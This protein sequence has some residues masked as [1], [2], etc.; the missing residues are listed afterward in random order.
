MFVVK[1]C[2]V[3]AGAR[4][5]GQEYRHRAELPPSPIPLLLVRPRAPPGWS[6]LPGHHSAPP[7]NTVRAC[8]KDPNPSQR[9]QRPI[10][11]S[12]EARGSRTAGLDRD[13]RSNLHARRWREG[14]SNPYRP[15]AGTTSRAGMRANSFIV[16]ILAACL[17]GMA[18]A[19]IPDIVP[20]TVQE[21]LGPLAEVPALEDSAPAGR[22]GFESPMVHVGSIVLDRRLPACHRSR[23]TARRGRCPARHRAGERAGGRARGGARE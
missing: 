16:V 4:G 17:A 10:T 8:S 18:A 19:Q 1:D 7:M 3:P 15:L 21:A 11:R 5:E 12:K 23:S 22:M 20:I 9:L 2:R 6:Q 13:R 14:G